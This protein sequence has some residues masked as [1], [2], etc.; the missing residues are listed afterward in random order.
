MSANPTTAVNNPPLHV[1]IFVPIVHSG[2]GHGSSSPLSLQWHARGFAAVC[3]RGGRCGTEMLWDSPWGSGGE[4]ERDPDHHMVPIL[5]TP[6]FA[7]IEFLGLPQST[8][9]SVT[10]VSRRDIPSQPPVSSCTKYCTPSTPR[11]KPTRFA[12]IDSK[13]LKTPPAAHMRRYH[14]FSPNYSKKKGT[15]SGGQGKGGWHGDAKVERRSAAL[16]KLR[17]GEARWKS[18]RERKH[19]GGQWEK[20]AAI[21]SIKDAAPKKDPNDAGLKKR[22]GDTHEGLWRVY[23]PHGQQRKELG[24]L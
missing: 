5:A 24:T 12:P 16:V 23:R 6:S 10:K 8:K 19:I 9:Y 17:L 3:A 21:S 15:G 7:W 11:T 13:M 22:K 4:R 1:I 20:S 14:H 2:R 18:R